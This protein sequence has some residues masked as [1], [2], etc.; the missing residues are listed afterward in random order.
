[1]TARF[2]TAGRDNW[3]NPGNQTVWQRERM[4]GP[5]HPMAPEPRPSFLARALA[6]FHS[7]DQS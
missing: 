1:M 7:G 2:H 4:R 5:L 3:A 6:I